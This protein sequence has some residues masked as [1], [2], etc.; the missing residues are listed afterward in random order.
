MISTHDASDHPRSNAGATA[1]EFATASAS[2][3]FGLV[4]G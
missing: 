2:N 3:V 4:K 1:P